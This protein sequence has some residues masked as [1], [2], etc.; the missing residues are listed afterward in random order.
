ML[1]PAQIRLWD[2]TFAGEASFKPVSFPAPR[3]ICEAWF[4]FLS[5]FFPDHLFA[6]VDLS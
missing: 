2:G 5:G 6:V 1:A 3:F 4:D